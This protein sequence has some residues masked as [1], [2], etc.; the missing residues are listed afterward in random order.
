MGNEQWEVTYRPFAT[1]TTTALLLMQAYEGD[2]E[3]IVHERFDQMYGL[4]QG[5][6]FVSARK[7]MF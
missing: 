2:T 5:W 3:A 1:S 4:L 6:Q 7:G